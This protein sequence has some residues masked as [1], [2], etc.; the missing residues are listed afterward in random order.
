MH[1]VLVT[2]QQLFELSSQLRTLLLSE[3]LGLFLDLYLFLSCFCNRSELVDVF[4]SLNELLVRLVLLYDSVHIRFHG[5]FRNASTL[6]HDREEVCVEWHLV[7]ADMHQITFDL[8][9]VGEVEL[10]LFVV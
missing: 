4:L 10:E 5:R 6:F 8:L 7:V 2:V 3:Q 9:P 1:S